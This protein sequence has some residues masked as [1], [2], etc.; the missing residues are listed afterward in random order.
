[1]NITVE[2][3]SEE[4][5]PSVHSA[6]AKMFIPYEK[7]IFFSLKRLQPGPAPMKPAGCTANGFPI[8]ASVLAEG[9]K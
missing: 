8:P 1:M 3:R 5:N 4:G 6:A 7:D 2:P 9:D